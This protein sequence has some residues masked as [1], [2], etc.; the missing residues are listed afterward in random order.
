MTTLT[1]H[2]YQSGIDEKII[3]LH[4]DYYARH[5]G[6]DA[7]FEAQ[8][9]RELTEFIETFD[10]ARD[11]LWW[12]CREDGFVGSIAVDGSR[13]EPGLARLRWF[14]VRDEAQ[15]TG[16][17]AALLDQAVRFCREKRFGGVYLWTFAGLDAA[18]ALYERSGF[19]LVQEQEGD[20]WGPR[21][22]EQKFTL[23]LAVPA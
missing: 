3:A 9:N 22:T 16:A 21:I 1:L 23:S 7:R 10:P 20:G 13:G 8:V 5:W 11:G 14:I 4:A 12:A 6:F 19:S 17:G 15:G 18:R 2:Q